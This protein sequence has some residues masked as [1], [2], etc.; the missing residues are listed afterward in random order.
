MSGLLVV[1]I[2]IWFFGV[3]CGMGAM[4]WLCVRSSRLAVKPLKTRIETGRR[5]DDARRP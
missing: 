3:T 4:L 5:R 2:M 1:V